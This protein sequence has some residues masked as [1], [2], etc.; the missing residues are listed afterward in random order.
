MPCRRDMWLQT[1]LFF[2]RHIASW[3]NL[4][5][6]EDIVR[7]LHWCNMKEYRSDEIAAKK[8]VD[9]FWRVATFVDGLADR[10][11]QHFNMY[12]DCDVYWTYMYVQCA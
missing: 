6:F 4:A 1:S 12:Q 9:C 2:N 8:K 5:R 10:F 3:M 7:N 11:K